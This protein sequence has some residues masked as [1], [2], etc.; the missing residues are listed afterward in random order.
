MICPSCNRHVEATVSQC[1]CGARWVGPPPI[2]SVA[3]APRLVYGITALALLVGTVGVQLVLTIRSLYGSE[4]RWTWELFLTTSYLAKFVLPMLMLAG[5]VA[6][7]GVRQAKRWPRQY[8]A[9]RLSRRCL[10]AALLVFALDAGVLLARVPEMLENH[11][12]KQEAYTRARMYQ[13]HDLIIK[14]RQQYG[15]YPEHLLDLQEMDPT[16]RPILDYWDHQL[17]YTPMSAEFASRQGPVPFQNLE[18]VSRGRDGILGTADDIV[19]RDGVI[20][21]RSSATMEADPGVA[22]PQK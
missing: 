15:T 21:P 18:L 1:D 13:L 3:A 7:R 22:P 16:I 4:L 12:L 17:V 8:G 5:F 11:R 2:E 14:Y 19:M 9:G 20:L 10:V 6:W